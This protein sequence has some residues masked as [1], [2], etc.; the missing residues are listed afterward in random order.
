MGRGYPRE[1]AGSPRAADRVAAILTGLS[2]RAATVRPVGA[3]V[4][5]QS[6]ASALALLREAAED[7]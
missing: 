6:P 4:T 2:D 5:R 3:P 7:G 1:S